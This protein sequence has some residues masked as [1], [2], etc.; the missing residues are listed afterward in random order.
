[1]EPN[2]IDGPELTI[3][4]SAP[5]DTN[6]TKEDDDLT[7]FTASGVAADALSFG[8][9]GAQPIMHRGSESD[10]DRMMFLFEDIKRKMERDQTFPALSRNDFENALR[11]N[12][13]IRLADI[14][15]H[16]PL[17]FAYMTYPQ[18]GRERIADALDLTAEKR[19]KA[20]QLDYVLVR[21]KWRER[22]L[23]QILVRDLMQIAKSDG[24]DVM[25]AQAGQNDETYRACLESLG[26]EVREH[27]TPEKGEPMDIYKKRLRAK[28]AEK[29]PDEA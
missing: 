19:A 7:D 2:E 11:P 17:G 14:G 23:D 28:A 15:E 9:N 12:G 1:M 6:A 16:L 27:L 10:F 21:P 13:Y 5:K 4:Y 26:F 3:L 20:S 8:D 18:E 24:Y 22:Q 25:Y 29:D